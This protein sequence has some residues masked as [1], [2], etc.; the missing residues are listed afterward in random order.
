MVAAASASA[1]IPTTAARL[2]LTRAKVMAI[3][4]VYNAGKSV[5]WTDAARDRFLAAPATRRCPTAIRRRTRHLARRSHARK[6][7][8][9]IAGAGRPRGLDTGTRGSERSSE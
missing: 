2:R 3:G 8:V 4:A 7:E 5:S 1:T 6:I 9:G